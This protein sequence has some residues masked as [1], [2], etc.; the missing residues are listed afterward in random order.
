MFDTMTLTKV[1]G[2]ICGALLVFLLGN[3]AAELLYSTEAGGHGEEHAQAYVIEVEDAGDAGAAEEEGP[4]FATLLA[5]A[6]VDAGAKVFG[7]CK[8]CHKIDG[9]N[10]TGPHLDGVVGRA[11]D[12][13]DGFAYSGALEEHFDTWSPE[14]L[15]VFL[16][17]PKGAAPGTK[18]SFA[19]LKKAQERADLVAYLQSLGG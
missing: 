11:V 9:S 18:M 10:A 4:D 15:N 2:A 13:V 12:A 5:S 16:E 1:G 14:N 6:D 7:K 8:A 19:G 17:N 3:W